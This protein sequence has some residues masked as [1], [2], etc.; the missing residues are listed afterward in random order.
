MPDLLDDEFDDLTAPEIPSGRPAEPG[1]TITVA[2]S[3]V[4]ISLGGTMLGGGGVVLNRGDVFTLTSPMIEAS[5]DRS[6][7]PTWP[8]LIHDPAAQVEKWGHV[9]FILGRA[10]IEPWAAPGDATWELHHRRAMDA[11][12]SI[13]DADAR[14][15]ALAGVRERFGEKPVSTS[16]TQY[17]DHR[18]EVA[19][20]DAAALRQGIRGNY[21]VY[22]E[23]RHGH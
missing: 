12:R 21:G 2:M 4:T 5:R 3:G 7:E 6:G 13:V 20:A 8:A 19:A 15:D 23:A 22:R 1:D 14:A 16:Y 10:E 17:R 18:A 9:R 11:A